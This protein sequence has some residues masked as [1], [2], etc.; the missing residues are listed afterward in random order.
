M[1]TLKSS[2]HLW[3]FI[4]RLEFGAVIVLIVL[5]LWLSLYLK[6]FWYK[7]SQELGLI[8]VLHGMQGLLWLKH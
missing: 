3:Y 8:S 6:W 7:T 4:W 1:A 5:G 2:S